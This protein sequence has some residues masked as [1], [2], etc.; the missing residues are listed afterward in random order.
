MDKVA[1]LAEVRAMLNKVPARMAG[2]DIKTV[3]D[4]KAWHQ[5]TTKLINKTQSTSNMWSI[6]MDARS[7]YR[8]TTG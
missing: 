8:D 7:M 2:A 4:F 3:R 6:L 5:K 1:M